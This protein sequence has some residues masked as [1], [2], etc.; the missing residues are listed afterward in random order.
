MPSDSLC[1]SAG[2]I[3]LTSS[4]TANGRRWLRDALCSRLFY[5]KG[6][7]PWRVAVHSYK[8]ERSDLKRLSRWVKLW[9]LPAMSFAQPAT[10]RQCAKRS[11]EKSLH[12]Q[13]SASVIRFA[14][15][16]SA[17][18]NAG[19]FARPVAICGRHPFQLP[20]PRF[21]SAGRIKQSLQQLGYLHAQTVRAKQ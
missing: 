15:G 9:S 7:M 18:W 8:L 11:P 19:S 14:C 5:R 6:S 16:K 13:I 2:Y 1:Q 10:L 17:R 20:R 4:A 3:V 12:R 21:L